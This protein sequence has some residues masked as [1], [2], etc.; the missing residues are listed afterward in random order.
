[1]GR[2]FA[3]RCCLMA[4]LAGTTFLFVS[5]PGFGSQLATAGTLRNPRHRT[6]PAAEGPSPGI[7]L[8]TAGCWRQRDTE[9]RDPAASSH[10][11]GPV[12]AAA[13]RRVSALL[14]PPDRRC[15]AR[16]CTGRLGRRGGLTSI[17]P[18]PWP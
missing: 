3:L 14:T 16:R 15:Q 10:A 8:P 1:M 12:R 13:W 17:A 5:P 2:S 6:T 7:G 4:L 11:P 9:I 18:E